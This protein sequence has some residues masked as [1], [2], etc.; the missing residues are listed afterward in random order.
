MTGKKKL[1]YVEAMERIQTIL[2]KIEA[3]PGRV[4]ID[5]LIQ[6][7]EEAASLISCCK[8]KLF[9]AEAKIQKVLNSIDDDSERQS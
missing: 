4:D 6:D 2:S 7:V 5:S 9:N 1:R 8:E 3:D